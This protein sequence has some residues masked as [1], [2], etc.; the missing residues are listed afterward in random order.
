MNRFFRN[1]N[2]FHRN[3]ARVATKS[4]TATA[5]PEFGSNVTS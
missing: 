5:V 2:A 3:G 1:S 4:K